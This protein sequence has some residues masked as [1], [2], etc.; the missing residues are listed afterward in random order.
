LNVLELTQKT[1]DELSALS[2]EAIRGLIKSVE[3]KALAGEHS[4]EVI[5]IPIKH[6]FSEG[7]YAR[8][9]TM[10]KGSF[11]L[12]KIHKFRNLNILSKGEVSII[13][14]DGIERVKAPYTYVGSAGAQRLI[15]AHEECVWTVIHGTE[16]TNVEKIE[17]KFIAKSIEELEGGQKCLG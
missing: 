6:H 11:V 14:I 17:E 2:K 3:E 1:A 15:F 7:V 9:M 12:G 13:S 5:E 16:E 4:G 10:P 8:E